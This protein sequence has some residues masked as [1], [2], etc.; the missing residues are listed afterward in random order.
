MEL[1]FQTAVNAV[2][3]ASAYILVSL[4]FAFLFNMLGILNLAHGAVYMVAGYLAYAFIV[5]LGM[6]HWF[7]MLLATAIVAALGVFLERFCFRPFVG[8]FNRLVM[9]C[10]AITVIL[11]TSVNIIIG[12]QQMAIPTFA[13]G[14]FRSGF[15]SVNWDRA[16]TF[17]V[18]A[19]ILILT[20]LFVNRSKW[21]RQ[22]QAIS[23]NMEGASLQGINIGRISAVACAVG[24]ALAGIAGCLMG[25]LYNLSPFMGQ[26]TLVKVLMIIIL[27]GVG[28]FGGIFIVGLIL[29]ILYGVLPVLL[30]GAASDAIAVTIFMILLLFRPQ[31]FFGHE[32]EM[33]ETPP[34]DTIPFKSEG[35]K[36]TGLMLLGCAALVAF[37]ALLPTMVDSPYL[38][39]II[40]LTFIYVIVSVS[41]RTINISGQ[42]P[43]AHGAFMGIGAYLSAMGAKWLGISPWIT[44]PAAAFLSGGI[45]MLFGYPFSRLRS[46]YYA[47]GSLFLGVAITQIIQAGG[48]WT[49][50]YSG[51]TGIRPLILGSRVPYYYFF[52][53]LSL[54]SVIALYR[55]EFSRIGMNLKAISQSYLVASSVGVNEGWYRVLAVGMGCFFVG[56]AGGV[57]AHYNLVLSP[58]SFDMTA[59]LWMVMYALIGGIGSFAGPIVG[60][61]ILVL[62]PEFFRG[63][64]MY[65]P[66]ISAGILLIVV[67]LM[68]GGLASLPYM[69]KSFR[70]RRKKEKP[71]SYGQSD[72][73]GSP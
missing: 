12:T 28:S 25:T 67:Y 33:G 40:S 36:R 6:S 21:G 24:F 29:G 2:I 38:L 52:L 20:T 64:K 15:I 55:F 73:E 10:V 23:Q 44:I 60:T 56:L 59:T 54:V 49:G 57:Y 66:Y 32:V 63:L 27:A 46:L 53:G 22:M 61:A 14:V 9:I 39:H 34:A 42:F 18:G 41:L 11:T 13:Q 4:G 17:G 65:S 31:G 7:A 37:L 71:V 68:P 16:I 43:L 62:I 69:I 48:M 8:D 50:G 47:M 51:L 72:F 5:G 30:P 35:K 19:G 26:S 1:V 3:L 45:G 70:A 58:S